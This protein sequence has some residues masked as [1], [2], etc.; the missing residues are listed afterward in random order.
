MKT[1]LLAFSAVVLATVAGSATLAY[2]S[3]VYYQNCLSYG[4]QGLQNVAAYSKMLTTMSGMLDQVSQ[5]PFVALAFLGPAI[6]MN[7]EVT[8]LNKKNNDLNY[9]FSKTCPAAYA[10][11]ANSTEVRDLRALWEKTDQKRRSIHFGS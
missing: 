8:A 7:G 6:E 4:K 3:S 9:A 5:N 1:K 2:R 10:E 11:F